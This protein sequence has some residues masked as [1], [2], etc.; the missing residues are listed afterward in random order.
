MG[1]FRTNEKGQELKDKSN[2]DKDN[3]KGEKTMKED[4]HNTSP[5]PVSPPRSSGPWPGRCRT[6]PAP[7]DPAGTVQYRWGT[8]SWRIVCAFKAD[9][10]SLSTVSVLSAL[11][12][13]LCPCNIE[14]ACSPL[15]ELLYVHV[16]QSLIVLFSMCTTESK[17][18]TQR[19][20][21]TP[22]A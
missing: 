15:N 5:C 9:S 16:P 10:T 8:I 14:S 20:V 13:Q 2:K 11:R 22:C 18:T 7:A 6:A 21:L 12:V 4:S 17:N 1:H 3:E 19:C